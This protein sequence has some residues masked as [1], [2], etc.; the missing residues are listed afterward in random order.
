[1]DYVVDT[2]GGWD[3]QRYQGLLTFFVERS[4][5]SRLYSALFDEDLKRLSERTPKFPECPLDPMD[6]AELVEKVRTQDTGDHVV[7][8]DPHVVDAFDVY[9]HWRWIPTG[10]HDDRVLLVVGISKHTVDT[11]LDIWFVY[12]ILALL[13]VSALYILTSMIFITADRP[14]LY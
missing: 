14:R 9:F 1:M 12:G 10:D 11:A 7:H 5:D 2:S 6:Y 4:D 3:R 13:T 8:Y